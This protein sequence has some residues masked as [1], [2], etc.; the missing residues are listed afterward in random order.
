MELNYQIALTSVPF[1]NSYKNVLRFDSRSGQEAYFQT[2]TLFSISPKVNFNVGS[3][4]A[5]NVIYD[6]REDESIN[7]LL[8]KNYCIIKDSSPNK[9]LNYY[10]YFVTNAVQDCDNRIKMSLELDIFQTYYIDLQFGDSI[11]YKAHLNRFINNGDGTV[12]FDGRTTSKLFEREDIKN[13]AKRL[14]DRQKINIYNTGS[15]EIDNW[16]NDNV[17][18]WIYLYTAKQQFTFYDAKFV[19]GQDKRYQAEPSTL[20]IKT[21]ENQQKELQYPTQI[22]GIYNPFV[23]M[24]FPIFASYYNTI[25]FVDTNDETI[26]ADLFNS[27]IDE[28]IMENG[29]DKIYA[30]KFSTTPPFSTIGDASIIT[31]S[32]GGST[33][34]IK[35]TYQTTSGW[36]KSIRVDDGL[37]DYFVRYPAICLTVQNAYHI[38]NFVNDT[39]YKFNISEIINANKNYKYN[40]KLLNSDYMGLTIC[41]STENGFE[42]DLQKLNKQNLEIMLT[43]PFV[44]DMTKKFIRFSNLDGVYI[45]KTRENLTGFVLNNDTSLALTND[46]YKQMLAN[47][48]NFFLQNSINRNFNLVQGL[49]SSGM[50]IAGGAGNPLATV[51]GVIGGVNTIANFAKS[52]INEDLTIDNLKNAPDIIQGAKGNVIF[53]N[54]YS[55][56]GIIIEKYDILEN[57]KEMINDYMCLYGF[58]YNRVDNIK[59]VDNIRKYYNFVRADI[60]TISGINISEQVHQKFRSCFANGVRFWNTDTFSYEKENYELWLVQA[61]VIVLGKTQTNSIITYN[62]VEQNATFYV[63]KENGTISIK[64]TKTPIDVII[65]TDGTYQIE[66]V[67]NYEIKILYQNVS[68]INISIQ[69][70]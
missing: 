49:T 39:Q 43:E 61:K 64:S 69:P 31:N 10:Y 28:F 62:N 21:Y 44:P 52:K 13:V 57:E 37:N 55:Q 2:N 54:M 22:C 4:Y 35:G 50:A 51:G 7:E 27:A 5:T 3:L 34:K 32:L 58:N 33:L 63:N 59:N 67:N 45:E 38:T 53:E 16:L 20:I 70:Y 14:V 9:T 12:S 6:C 42:Y 60:E 15:T 46:Q 19:S 41:D 40:P 65:N 66:R 1:D 24:A 18:G 25:R 26:N 36:N 48:K 47:N 68:N 29:V 56:N 11:I 30:L 17:V 23:C 8:N